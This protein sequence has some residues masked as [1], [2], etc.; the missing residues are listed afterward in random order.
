MHMRVDASAAQAPRCLMN[1]RA[2][3]HKHACNV[4]LHARMHRDTHMHLQTR[5]SSYAHARERKQPL[6]HLVADSTCAHTHMHAQHVRLHVGMH[7][8]TCTHVQTPM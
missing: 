5:M 2:R 4:R 1:T 7:R 3:A 8:D 6:K